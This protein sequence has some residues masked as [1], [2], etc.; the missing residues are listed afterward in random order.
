M[1]SADTISISIKNSN[2]HG[3]SWGANDRFNADKLQVSTLDV[4]T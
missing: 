4:F 1:E 3:F 2:M